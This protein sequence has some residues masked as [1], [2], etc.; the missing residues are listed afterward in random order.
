MLTSTHCWRCGWLC[1]ALLALVMA[2]SALSGTQDRADDAAAAQQ[3]LYH[4]V[5]GYAEMD[6]LDALFAI[7]QFLAAAN[8]LSGNFVMAGLIE[9]IGT[10]GQCYERAGAL[11]ARTYT[12]LSAGKFGLLIVLNQDRVIG[13]FLSCVTRGPAIAQASSHCLRSGTFQARDD[14]YFY[15]Y[16]GTHADFCTALAGH[17]TALSN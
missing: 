13:N 7:D 16:A 12:H 2:C 9:R 17:F 14:R 5:P 10:L 4:D 1:V 15:L 8:L 6:T 11:A 3:F